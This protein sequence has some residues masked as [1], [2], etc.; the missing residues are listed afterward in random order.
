MTTGMLSL[1]AERRRILASW[2]K[3]WLAAGKKNP[4]N[5]ISTTGR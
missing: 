3:V 5:W 1:P 4:S 2:V